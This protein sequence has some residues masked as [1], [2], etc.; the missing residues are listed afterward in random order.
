MQ[1]NYA[2]GTQNTITQNKP[3]QL[4]PRGLVTSYNLR[5]G[6]GAGLFSKEKVKEVDTTPPHHHHHNCFTALFPGPPV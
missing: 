2:S 6:N 5:A 1:N 4:K 3:K